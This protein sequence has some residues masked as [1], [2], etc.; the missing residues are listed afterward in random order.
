MAICTGNTKGKD[1]Y[2]DKLNNVIATYPTTAEE[3]RA[4]EILRI[5]GVKGAALPGGVDEVESDFEMKE[6][7][8]HYII[9][10]FDYLCGCFNRR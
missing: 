7:A 9:I 1:A 2:I 5:L 6:N 10:V 8:L 4:K 3:K